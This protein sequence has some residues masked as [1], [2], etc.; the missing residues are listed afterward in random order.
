M[1]ASVLI[2]EDDEELGYQLKAYLELNGFEV[3]RVWNGKEA[4]SAI[5]KKNY[6]ILLVDVMMPEEDGFTLIRKIREEGVS[7]PFLFLTARGFK[8]DVLHGLKLGAEDYIIKPFDPD[9][10]VLRLQNIL[11]RINPPSISRSRYIEIGLFH[12][13][14]ENLRLVS[15]ISQK[16]LTVKEGEL[17]IYLHRHQKELIKRKD[18]LGH[19]WDEPDFFSGRSLD[20]F[21]TR[22]RKLLAEDPAIKIE[23][24]RGIGFRFFC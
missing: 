15:A 24:V 16:T 4:R 7:S 3:E 18:I 21:I 6:D 14:T 17:L 9:E 8:E 20:V 10:V 19:L 12:Y 22:L 2:I 5:K 11:R 1:K 13:D 23:S